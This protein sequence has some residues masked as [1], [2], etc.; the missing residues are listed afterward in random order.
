MV[1]LPNIINQCFGQGIL[2]FSSNEGS[3]ENFYLIKIL[4]Y[5]SI[6]YMKLI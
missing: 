2:W 5:Q 1:R 6:K 3:E 4:K